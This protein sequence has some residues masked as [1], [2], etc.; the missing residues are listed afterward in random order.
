MF[1]IKWDFR[2]GIN[3]EKSLEKCLNKEA[4]YPEKDALRV[5]CPRCI[6][7]YPT[8]PAPGTLGER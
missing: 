6:L 8:Y 2:L 1:N 4:R 5:G 3:P 7:G